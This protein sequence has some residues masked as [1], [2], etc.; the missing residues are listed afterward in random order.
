MDMS[1]DLWWYLIGFSWIFGAT[2]ATPDVLGFFFPCPGDMES[3]THR[4]WD[5]LDY[6]PVQPPKKRW[7]TNLSLS[8]GL[9][10]SEMGFKWV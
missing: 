1:W 2:M 6:D 3:P 8:M 9:L 7:R 4:S 5:E 10:P